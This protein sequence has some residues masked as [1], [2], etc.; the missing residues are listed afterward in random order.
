MPKMSDF[1]GN[2]G[3]LVARFV[4]ETQCSALQSAVVLANES[5]GH[6]ALPFVRPAFEER[7]WMAYLSSLERPTRERLELAPVA[8]AAQRQQSEEGSAP[9]ALTTSR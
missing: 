4:L 9:P 7:T 6:L 2:L 8:A 5:L 3:A 1:E